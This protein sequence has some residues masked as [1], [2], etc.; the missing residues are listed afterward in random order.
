MTNT[1]F[2]SLVFQIGDDPD[3]EGLRDSPERMV[4]SWREI[5]CGYEQDPAEVFTSFSADG[6]NQL[7]LLRD[8]EM[9][10]VCEHHMLPFFG[11]AH[12]GYIPSHE[13]KRVVGISKL[14]RLL[15]IFSRRLQTQ[16]RI[17]EQVT[18]AIME[19][20]T[21]VGAACIIQAEHLCMRMRGV[22]KQNSTVITSS[23]KGVFLEDSDS[24][25]AARSELMGLIK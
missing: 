7:V 21:P 5:F 13:I 12:I 15:E 3:R 6:Y 18:C 17:C 16:E 9:Y 10:S 11:R 19:H 20:L 2:R 25:R 4:K 14:A 22:S 23:L 24:G 8:V 1:F